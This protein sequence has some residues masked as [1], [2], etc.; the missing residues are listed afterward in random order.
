MHNF[1]YILTIWK[2]IRLLI[3][4]PRVGCIDL[5]NFLC[6]GCCCLDG[7]YILPFKITHLEP[8]NKIFALILIIIIII[9]I[10]VRII[11]DIVDVGDI[12]VVVIWQTSPVIIE[13]FKSEPTALQMETTTMADLINLYDKVAAD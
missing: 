9:T 10:I 5:T 11:R 8:N 2:F 6:F 4:L 1:K 12:F 7:Y 3:R 13:D